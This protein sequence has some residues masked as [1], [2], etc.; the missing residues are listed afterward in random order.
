MKAAARPCNLPLPVQ[1]KLAKCSIRQPSLSMHLGA[2]TWQGCRGGNVALS[3]P[4]AK[5]L[6]AKEASCCLSRLQP[7]AK[8]QKASISRSPIVRAADSGHTEQQA[9]AQSDAPAGHAEVIHIYFLQ[10]MDCSSGWTC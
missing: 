6:R 9:V 1:L 8:L 2:N 7:P 4:S 10:P 5:R 3:T